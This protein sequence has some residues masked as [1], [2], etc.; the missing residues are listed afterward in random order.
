MLSIDFLKNFSR[1]VAKPQDELHTFELWGFCPTQPLQP[2]VCLTLKHFRTPFL[3]FLWSNLAPHPRGTSALGWRV[4][5]L[6]TQKGRQAAK[7]RNARGC[8]PSSCEAVL[9]GPL[10]YPLTPKPL[11]SSERFILCKKESCCFGFLTFLPLALLA[12]SH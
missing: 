10:C 11:G 9:T 3:T 7:H 2:S 5:R 1:K 8:S 6:S 12:G 4:H